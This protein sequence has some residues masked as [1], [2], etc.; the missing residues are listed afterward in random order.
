MA[1]CFSIGSLS[2]QIRKVIEL[3]VHQ[4]QLACQPLDLGLCPAVNVKIEFTAQPVLG[5]LSVLAHHDDGSLNRSQHRKDQV[6][7]YERIRVPG[8]F[9]EPDV[10]CSVDCQDDAER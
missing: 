6:E 5:V 8:F 3:V 7:Q 1:G 10:D 4:V 2:K 9:G